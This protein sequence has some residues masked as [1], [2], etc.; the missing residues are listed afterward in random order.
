MS[1]YPT[2]SGTVGANVAMS[3]D[4]AGK[5]VPSG[6]TRASATATVSNATYS[7]GNAIGSV[8]QFTSL[9]GSGWVSK[10]IIT[11]PDQQFATLDVLLFN[12]ALATTVTDNTALMLNDADRAKWIGVVHVSD[13][14]AYT[15]PTLCVANANQTYVL[16]TGTTIYAVMVARSAVAPTP[17]ALTWNLALETAR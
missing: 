8:E 5:G 4:P 7:I 15:T 10:F 3:L 17:S 1:E 16:P 12:A 11:M 6:M 14:A 13:C 9:P 2:A